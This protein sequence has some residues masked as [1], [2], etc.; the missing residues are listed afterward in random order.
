MAGLRAGSGK[1]NLS[2]PYFDNILIKGVNTP[3][4]KATPA[5]PG[6]AAIYPSAK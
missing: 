1:K 5:L 4:P 6:Q 3:A 2:T